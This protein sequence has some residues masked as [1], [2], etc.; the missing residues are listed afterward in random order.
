MHCLVSYNFVI[1]EYVELFFKFKI[2]SVQNQFKLLNGFSK[3]LQIFLG[4]LILKLKNYSVKKP[5]Q[6]AF[7]LMLFFKN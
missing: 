1:R 6:D 3:K 4:V 5:I 7:E 2:R